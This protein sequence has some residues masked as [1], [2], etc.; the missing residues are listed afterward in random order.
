[1][2]LLQNLF[3]LISN[4][5]EIFVFQFKKKINSQFFFS[6]RNIRYKIIQ[7]RVLFYNESVI[8]AKRKDNPGMINELLSHMLHTMKC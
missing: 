1:M 6:S 5:S 2:S 4:L 7:M 3:S 8:Y